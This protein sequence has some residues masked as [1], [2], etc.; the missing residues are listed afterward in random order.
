[1]MMMTRTMMADLL[2]WGPKGGP[3]STSQQVHDIT[4]TWPTFHFIINSSI[5]VYL[6]THELSALTTSRSNCLKLAHL[7]Y[8]IYQTNSYLR[9]NLPSTHKLHN[10]ARFTTR[11]FDF[12][13]HL[14]QCR[15][16]A[17]RDSDA[18]HCIYQ[19]TGWSGFDY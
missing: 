15:S 13:I 3:Y 19:P 9:L 18:S 17:R 12:P 7:F 2:P 16:K 5:Q 11:S 8:Y 10:C 1:M 6:S 4:Y 14:A